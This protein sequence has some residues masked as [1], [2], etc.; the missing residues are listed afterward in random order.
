MKNEQKKR[1][2]KDAYELLTTSKMEKIQAGQK[3]SLQNPLD[4]PDFCLS[5]CMVCTGCTSCV[6]CIA[7]AIII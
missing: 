1:L 6:G 7:A 5:G 4:S 3:S 2:F